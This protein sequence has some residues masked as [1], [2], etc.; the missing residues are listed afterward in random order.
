ME[1]LDRG[2]VAVRSGGGYFLSWRL[3]GNEGPDVAFNLYRGGTRLNAAPLTAATSYLDS[4]APAGSA[5]EV[6]AVADGAEQSGGEKALVLSDPYLSIPL[7]RP[8]GGTTPD[9]VAYT[10]SPNDLSV[11]DFDGDGRYEIVVKWDPSNSHDNSQAGH[12]GNVFLDAYTLEG[13]RLWRIDLGR[14]IRAGAHYTQFLV[15]DF[16]GDGLAELICKTAPGTRDASGAYLSKG[17]A[18]AA[19]HAADYRNS[20][21]YILSGPEYLTVFGPDGKEKATLD[22]DPPR[23]SVSSWGDSYGNRVDRFLAGVAYLDGK[24]PSALFCRGYYNGQSGKG[25][26]RTFIWA[27]DWRDG[28]LTRRWTFDTDA[29]GLA[30][31]IHQGAHSLTVGDVDGD[32][33]DDL[34]YGAMAIG[35]DGKTLYNTGLCHG[36][37]L[38]MSDM[39]PSRPGLE[40]WMVHEDPSCYGSVGL[41]FRDART[42]KLIFGVDGEGAD[43]GRGVAGDIDPRYPGYE[44]WGSRGG[45]MSAGGTRIADKTP[46][47]KNFMAWWDGDLLRELLDDT[48]IGKWDYAAG[49]SASLLD[50]GKA[51]A[52]SDN[53]TKAV[54]GLS[55]DILGDWREEVIWRHSDNA[56]LLLY[57]TTIAT[58]YRFP[59]LMHDPKY[60]LDVAWQNVGY[61]QP[62]HPGFFLGDGMAYPPPLPDIAIPG[63]TSPARVFPGRGP[64]PTDRRDGARYD[65]TGRRVRGVAGRGLHLIRTGRGGRILV[66]D[67]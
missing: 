64:V 9:G 32:G 22:Y 50:A 14:N 40:V 18:A 55:A 62:P 13:A 8:A 44:M 6:R 29:D 15:Y 12:T 42:G 48:G 61:N 26:G 17:P 43:V 2:F 63:A 41:E 11:G 67:L 36:D 60:R 53:G 52:L 59:T 47:P 35:S 34:V 1:R 57:T 24:R 49:K 10:Y 28:R 56:H 4:S 37:A 19:D 54:P 27:V 7:Q 5:Y 38:H 58:Q 20:D 46:G 39:L 65:L 66:P 23:G 33:R 45:L 51:G 16:D 25:P 21:G 30:G 3:W 31:F